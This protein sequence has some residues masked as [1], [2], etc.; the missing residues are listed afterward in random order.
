MLKDWYSAS[1]VT[2][3]VR[4]SLQI[5]HSPLTW[6]QALLSSDSCDGS[7]NSHEILDNEN[8]VGGHCASCNDY[9]HLDNRA[10]WSILAYAGDL[11]KR[12]V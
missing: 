1:L 2:L 12:L 3:H 5:L 8:F 11:V 7:V 10:E 9:L 4:L 6:T